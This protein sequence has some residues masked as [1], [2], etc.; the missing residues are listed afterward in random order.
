VAGTRLPKR[1][2]KKVGLPIT[3]TKRLGGINVEVL[4]VGDTH[5]IPVQ[6]IPTEFLLVVNKELI[7]LNRRKMING[8]LCLHFKTFK[9]AFYNGVEADTL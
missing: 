5:Y 9:E 4:K 6:N 7:D 8:R 3:V 1:R 2:R